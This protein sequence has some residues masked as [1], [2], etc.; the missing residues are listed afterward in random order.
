MKT[1]ILRD[2]CFDCMHNLKDTDGNIVG[3]FKGQDQCAEETLRCPE[4]EQRPTVY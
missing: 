2:I 3:C 4:K 1:E